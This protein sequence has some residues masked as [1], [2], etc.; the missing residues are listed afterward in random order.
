MRRFASLA[1]TRKLGYVLPLIV[2]IAAIAT[3]LYDLPRV[4]PGLWYDEAYYALD[5]AWIVKTHALQIFFPGNNGREPLMPYL[6]ALAMH[7]LGET[8]Y[9]L[10]LVSALT[11]VLTVALLY[12][13]L[14]MMFADEPDRRWLGLIAAGG[15]TF[16]LWYLV[17]SRTG[18]RAALFPTFFTLVAWFFWRAW[19]RSRSTGLRHSWPHWALA[20]VTLGVS[21][22][23]YLS[24]RLLPLVF[25]L[26][27]GAATLLVERP[28]PCGQ[29]PAPSAHIHRLTLGIGLAVMILCAALLS[30]P[31]GLYFLQHPNM[32]FA[33][34]G[35]VFVLNQIAQGRT[36]WPQQI[37]DAIRVFWDGTDPHW[38]HNLPDQPNFSPIETIGFWV[39]LL[40][41]LR[42]FQ[43]P[44]YCFLLVS[45]FVLWLPALLSVPAVYTLRLSGMLPVYYAIMAIGWKTI[46]RMLGIV[47]AHLQAP[48]T[49]MGIR[50]A[51]ALIVLVALAITVNSAYFTRWARTP[52]VYSQ[53]NGPLADLAHYIASWTNQADV[54]VPLHV[55][56]HPT[57]YF[58]L[59]SQFHETDTP[60]EP[61]PGRAVMLVQVP[62]LYLIPGVTAI[63]GQSSFMWLS[64][65]NAKQ[66]FAYLLHL[67]N[68]EDIHTLEPVGDPEELAVGPTEDK[69]AKLITYRSLTP[70]LESMAN[71]APVSVYY[72]WGHQVALT[73][74]QVLPTLV[75]TGDVV[76][77][78]LYW[79]GITDQP[80]EY[81]TFIHLLDG[82]GTAIGQ[83]DGI[84][85]SEEQRWRAQKLS[86]EQHI[87][88]IPGTTPAGAYIFR[89]GLIDEHS[90]APL[91]IYTSGGQ[92]M[93]DH[94]ELGLFYV[95][96][97]EYDP[98][99][100]D[101]PLRATFG[102]KISILGYSLPGYKTPDSRLC[103]RLYWQA[104]RAVEY[105]YT[106]FV[107]L[108][109]A[110]NMR[111]AGY[112]AQPL[113]GLYPTSRWQPGEVVVSDFVLTLPD[114]LAAGTYRL[115]TGFYSL[116]SMERLPVAAEDAVVIGDD[117]LSLREVLLSE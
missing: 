3:R 71:V 114:E 113:G 29:A 34:S 6:G 55:Y 51:T 104:I 17:M 73:G 57:M 109:D 2:L 106:A 19:W 11:A 32:F 115:V 36:T 65:D 23:C 85:L 1:F 78:N 105:D 33:R 21:Q 62:D 25:L 90:F 70:L 63:N 39:G 43:R 89:V 102:G 8:P 31:L 76:T 44:A 69:V 86:P 5:A 45:L 42:Y 9:A 83:F 98:R 93:G 107:Q 27:V 60:P 46:I 75:P 116:A 108:L 37:I 58:L 101:V 99:I 15:F 82:Q 59:Q 4:P 96:Q 7:F 88:Q 48:I 87:V 24:A 10:R 94:I 74:Y 66:G 112:D 67:A 54:L 52:M 72:D 47:G 49:R 95:T 26:F 97:N 103:V 16:S 64:R 53:Y 91:P 14:M 20:G 81:R 41:S 117:V 110:H 22:Y 50:I 35:D 30:M 13:W 80:S 40:T 18:H 100:P 111:V 12:R 68:P 84:S 56:L 38:R 28:T 79:H 77:L 61:R 92:L